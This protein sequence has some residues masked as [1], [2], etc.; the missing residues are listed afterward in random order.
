MTEMHGTD[1]FEL[2]GSATSRRALLSAALGGLVALGI[3][4]CGGEG[5]ADFDA[6]DGR[7]TGTAD[8]A[9]RALAG[10]PVEVWRDPG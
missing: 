5:S 10:V 4:A 7:S 8:P 2:N 9:G 3:S 6:T 1:L